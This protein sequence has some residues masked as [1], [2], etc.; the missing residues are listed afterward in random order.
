VNRITA[1]GVVAAPPGAE[2]PGAEQPA[3]GLQFVALLQALLTTLPNFKTFPLEASR[4]AG[5]NSSQLDV[6]SDPDL[7]V[8]LTDGSVAAGAVTDLA[9]AQE[10]SLESVAH[11]EHW[12]A[13]PYSVS[14]SAGAA[15]AAEAAMPALP[16]LPSIVEPPL[17]E[18][19]HPEVIS[20]RAASSELDRATGAAGTSP[21]YEQKPRCSNPVVGG[22]AAA[23]LAQFALPAS[24][25]NSELRTPHGGNDLEAT[26]SYATP[27]GR[28]DGSLHQT[29]ALSDLHLAAPGSRAGQLT[30]ES[31]TGQ[32]MAAAR[33]QGRDAPNV[34]A[35]ELWRRVGLL[36][37][38]SGAEAGAAS[39]AAPPERSASGPAIVD[40]ATVTRDA[41]E[42]LPAV[43]VVALT[44][45]GSGQGAGQE[46]S[47]DSGKGGDTLARGKGV[48]HLS[49]PLEDYGAEL[50]QGTTS[51]SGILNSQ[52]LTGSF[53]PRAA[54]RAA[55][56]T[57]A[58]V[59]SELA[60]RG[61]EHGNVN[62]LAQQTQQQITL[63]LDDGSAARLRITVRGERVEALIVEPDRA[64][65][66][67]LWASVE[68]LRAALQ[69]S[70]FPD[71]V[72][73]VRAPS[74]A[75]ELHSVMA[76]ANDPLPSR[77]AAE[78]Q[79]PRDSR[80]SSSYRRQ[81]EGGQQGQ[82]RSHQRPSRER[83]R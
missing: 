75:A 7:D 52:P 9:A 32:D 1:T 67:R 25:F 79:P 70:G 43:R 55:T 15:L 80:S 45:K 21:H 11:T 14:P 16:R 3:A 12:C 17:A 19:T 8:G 40:S 49:R 72:V 4:C 22:S 59:A 24:L 81:D 39:D 34:I 53:E 41:R 26:A 69:R 65:A 68:E 51:H 83:E 33:L 42:Q 56:L 54:G 76:A 50:A 60:A 66:G 23:A 36:A 18:T 63:R 73:V 57:A 48:R 44:Q 71:S 6:S 30:L 28:S 27:H 35:Q 64:L 77:A 5:H 29:A 2:L 61:W 58:Q 20:S 78:Q 37:P 62:P 47:A 82:G 31:S 10:Q 38:V 13:T 74:T 46:G